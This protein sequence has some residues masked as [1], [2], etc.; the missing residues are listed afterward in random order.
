MGSNVQFVGVDDG[1]A[2]TKIVLPNGRRF[3]L[4][5]QARAGLSQQIQLQEGQGAS[6]VF[7][8]NTPEGPFVAG[9]LDESDATSFDGY[10]TSA[11]NRVV[12][13]HSLRQAG[14]GGDVQVAIAT[15]LPV[16]RYYRRHNPNNELIEAKKASLLKNDV[17]SEDGVKL[18]KIISHEV[19]AEGIAAWIDYVMQRGALGKLEVNK[20]LEKERI[21]IVDIGGR[22]TDIAV[23]CNWEMTS[24][25]SSTLDVGMIAI[26]EAVRERLEDEHDTS[27]TD[28][29][30]L[31]AIDHGTIKLWGKNIDVKQAVVDAQI[32]VVSRIKTETLRC[33]GHGS[34][35]DHVIFVGGTVMA[36]GT[37][38]ND[39]F[40]NQS[41]G[42]DP[43]FANARGL[44]KC[45]EYLS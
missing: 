7:S 30:I 42:N 29:Q 43:A 39:W 31:S 45:A 44:Q 20:S 14:L 23:V 32:T 34:D 8:Y 35:L 15:G 28:S 25:R 24:S 9:D 38:V 26:R 33:L 2:E 5:S 18:A 37:Q 40:R 27:V 21:G 10:P 22:T 17:T 16:R 4:P 3:R 36:L 1:Y 12:V 11:M 41:I 19:V 6:R 13:A